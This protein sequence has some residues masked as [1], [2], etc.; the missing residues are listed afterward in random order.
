MNYPSGQGFPGQPGYPVG[1]PPFPP[2]RPSAATALSAGILALF[3]GIAG[4]GF[5]VFGV[6]SMAHHGF[7]A[8][9]VLYDLVFV[10]YATVLLVGAVLLLQRKTIGKVLVAGSCAVAVLAGLTAVVQAIMNGAAD[11]AVGFAVIIVPLFVFPIATLV[12]AL[13]P[14]TAKWLAPRPDSTSPQPYPPIQGPH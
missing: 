14:S 1:H 2:S 13:L 6:A 11:L 10:G 8:K 9:G 3:G 12:L 4:L 7:D 5:A